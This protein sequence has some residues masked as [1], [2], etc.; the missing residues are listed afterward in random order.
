[1]LIIQIP[2]KFLGYYTRGYLKSNILIPIVLLIILS[3][4]ISEVGKY[5]S[6]KKFL[7]TKKINNAIL[8]VIGW[9]SFESINL[10]SIYF[11]KLIFGFM[12]C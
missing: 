5:L 7:K 6:L 2:I 10:F 9:V 12:I 11:F 8:F 3:S 1:M 4:I